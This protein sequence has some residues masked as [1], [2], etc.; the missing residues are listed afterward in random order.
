VHAL[1][2][3]FTQRCELVRS[4]PTE[5]EFV[6]YFNCHASK[7]G[8][9]VGAIWQARH[10]V[11]LEPAMLGQFDIASSPLTLAGNFGNSKTDSNNID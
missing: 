2:Q 4:I 6:T 9:D 8:T 7:S 5:L 10:Q 11:G 1:S 3:L